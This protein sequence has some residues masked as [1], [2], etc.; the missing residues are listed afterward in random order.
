MSELKPP[1]EMFMDLVCHHGSI[2]ISCELCGRE[3]FACGSKV[4]DYEDGELEGLQAKAD[5][6]PD[7]YVA[8]HDADSI[9]WGDLDGKRVVWGCV[10]HRARR[11]EDFIWSHRDL[12][13]AYLKARMKEDLSHAQEDAKHLEGLDRTY[14]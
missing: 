9:S 5:R 11:F 2:R 10:C 14:P 13:I 4:I 1:S 3:H 6:E 8:H 7:K 12:I